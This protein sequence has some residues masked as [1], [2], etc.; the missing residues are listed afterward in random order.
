MGTLAFQKN[1]F[2]LLNSQEVGDLGLGIPFR[3]S[4]CSDQKP[5][6]KTE[7]KLGAPAWLNVS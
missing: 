4:E 3:G 7:T 6:T 1:P 2:R 5:E